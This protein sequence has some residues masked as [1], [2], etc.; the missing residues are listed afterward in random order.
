MG[1]GCRRC[2]WPYRQN[3]PDVVICPC[4]YTQQAGNPHPALVSQGRIKGA[5]SYEQSEDAKPRNQT[6]VA[7]IMQLTTSPQS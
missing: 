1:R 4:I 3:F 2:M 7:R 5:T 6:L